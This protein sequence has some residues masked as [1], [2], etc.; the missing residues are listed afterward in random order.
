MHPNGEISPR[1][2][3]PYISMGH[4]ECG[5]RRCVFY[6]RNP[7]TE[8]DF[9]HGH[10]QPETNCLQ[11]RPKRLASLKSLFFSINFQEWSVI[12]IADKISLAI[13]QRINSMAFF[14]ICH[15]TC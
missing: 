12:M 8:G 7:C 9:G 1:L 4:T 11:F 14:Y 13:L 3:T 15:Q 2:V 10:V 5:R 6:Y